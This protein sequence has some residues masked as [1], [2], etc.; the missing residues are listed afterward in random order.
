MRGHAGR[1]PRE[2]I[3][4]ERDLRFVAQFARV[5]LR[6]DPFRGFVQHD[7]V[8]GYEKDARQ[9]VGHDDDRDA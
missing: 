6:H 7:A 5:A 1:R 9:F 4:Y 2:E 3:V 8:V